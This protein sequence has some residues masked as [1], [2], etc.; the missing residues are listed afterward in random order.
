MLVNYYFSGFLQSKDN[1]AQAV[2]GRI[3]LKFLIFVFHF[4]DTTLGRCYAKVEGSRCS[5]PLMRFLT[6]SQCCCGMENGG[7]RGW[8]DPCTPCPLKGTGTLNCVAEFLHSEE[9]A[10]EDIK[11]QNRENVLYKP[12]FRYMHCVYFLE[13]Q[14]Y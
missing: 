14:F 6:L 11:L 8:D 5:E 4:S 10:V 12:Y 9:V 7:Q 1:F 13:N 2:T 3:P